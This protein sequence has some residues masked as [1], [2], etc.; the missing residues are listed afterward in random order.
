MSNNNSWN[1]FSDAID[2]SSYDTIPVGI[3]VKFRM[4]IK[5]GGFDNPDIGWTGGYATRGETGAII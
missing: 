5:P 3:L 2:Q 4:T 1:N